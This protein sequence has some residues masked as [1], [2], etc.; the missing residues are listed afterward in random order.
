MKKLNIRQFR[1]DG[2]QTFSP[3]VPTRTDPLY[4]DEADRDEQLA[5]LAE[6]IDQ[7]QNRMHAHGEYGLLVVFQAMDAAGKDSSIR[8]VFRGVNPSRFKIA[9]F[10]KPAEE[11]MKHDFLWRFWQELPE[12]GFIGIFNRSY[13]EEVLAMR[14]HPER[15]REGYIPANLLPKSDTDL[16]K[17]RFADIVHFEDYLFRNGFPIVKL[18][19]HVSKEEQ[20]QRLIAR[21]RDAEKQWKFSENDLEERRFWPD[22]ERAYADTINATATRNNPWYVIPSDDRL[23]Q[24]III[25]HIVADLLENLPTEFPQETAKE[26]AALIRKIEKQDAG[27]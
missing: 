21:L 12:R 8:R 27:N 1:Y 18:Y 25:G 22:Y 15:L 10:K 17:Q 4:T 5:R 13:Y 6:R 14:V 20:G 7:A 19:L 26:A 23:N 11:D 9:P 2:R 24:Q 3:D 16:W